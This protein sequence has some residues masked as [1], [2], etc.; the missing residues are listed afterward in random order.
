MSKAFHQNYNEKSKVH[1]LEVINHK[2]KYIRPQDYL[3]VN[4]FQAISDE[5]NKFK[6]K[7]W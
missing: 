1:Y 5:D 2:I 6:K 3:K 4:S 7:I